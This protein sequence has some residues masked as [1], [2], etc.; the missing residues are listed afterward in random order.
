[1]NRDEQREFEHVI[2]EGVA[3]QRQ[4]PWLQLVAVGG[5]AA[6]LHAGHRYSTDT[7][8]VT[9]LLEGRF[10]SVSE[11]LE[12]WEGWVTQ[13]IRRPFMILGERHGVQL[14]VRQIRRVVPL[15]TT[16]R[17]DLVVPTVEE[18]L[19]I[20][21]FMC[22]DRQAVRDFLD[23][24]ALADMLGDE[25]A[26]AALRYLNVLYEGEGNQTALTRFA[27]V[28]VQGPLDASRVDL[29]AYRGVQPPYDDLQY[30]TARC[31]AIAQS[32]LLLEMRGEVATTLTEFDTA[33]ESPSAGNESE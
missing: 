15:R 11:T 10:E 26:V 12:G 23:V 1:M 19:R 20:K 29:G 4:L 3:L 7:D 27:E 21:A 24:A 6:A 17:S 28:S 25:C 8:H 14:G 2:H 22:T 33:S 16:R 30:V 5:T 31:R 9:P 32:M 18:T 13:R